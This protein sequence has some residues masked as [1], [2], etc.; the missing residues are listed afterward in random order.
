VGN[1]NPEERCTVH[2]NLESTALSVKR[3]YDI[4]YTNHTLWLRTS[5]AMWFC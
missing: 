1:T 4:G 5:L 3:S 2:Y